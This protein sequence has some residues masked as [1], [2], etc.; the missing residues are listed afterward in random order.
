MAHGKNS[1]VG[2]DLDGSRARAVSGPAGGLP[3]PL[4][5]DGPGEEL[6]LAVSLEGR[7]PAAGRAGLAL[8]RKLPHLACLD[9]L[10]HLGT[11]R[12]WSGGRHRLDAGRALA[13]LF[14]HLPPAVAAARGVA[15]A[16]PAYLDPAQTSLLLAVAA[17]SRL[18]ARGAVA[19]PVALAL[20]A[21]ADQPW[22]GAVCVVDADDHA[23]TWSALWPEGGEMRLAET[24]V[25]PALAVR[26][27]KERL[28]DL[29]ADR[30]VRQTRRDPRDCPD[31]E[32]SLYEQIDAAWD[33]ARQGN[34]AELV[35]QTPQWYQ[36]VVLRPAEVAGCCAG[37]VGRAVEGLHALHAA[38]GQPGAVLVSASAAR[39]PGLVGALEAALAELVPAN[40]PAA[41]E[42]F[43][44]GLV[45]DGF[46]PPLVSVLPPDAAARAAH[47][48]AARWAQG[49][50]PAGPQGAAPLLP[51]QSADAGPP[52]L[53]FRGQD[54]PIRGAAFTLGRHAGCD[55][56]FDSEQY[57]A[58]SA[59]HCE[60]V[61]DRGAYVLLDRSRNGTLVNERPVVQQIAL[62]PGD[63][64]RLGP[65]GPLLRFLGQALGQR[66][67]TTA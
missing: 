40:D 16:V 66:K 3:Q 52:R 14:D 67:L 46:A 48:L 31:A 8:C 6:P 5:L 30:C 44:E 54:Y 19:I 24:Q 57:P 26:L 55:L 51:A 47:G 45:D 65:Q 35:V 9:F 56:V 64:V 10:A 38:V 33:A 37:F 2:V 62:H 29:A 28:L 63:W 59:R 27:W 13:V 41:E 49:E 50:L 1:L 7:H 34:L 32:Q 39:L 36:N 20:A 23:L 25:I 22:R 53:H 17:K 15:F 18:P 11:G 4:P 21:Y 60:I 43:G 42:D 12:E 58:V 61:F